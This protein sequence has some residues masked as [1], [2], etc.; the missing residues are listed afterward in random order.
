MTNTTRDIRQLPRRK[1]A[2]N[3]I[4]GFEDVARELLER[5]EEKNSGQMPDA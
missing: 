3:P 1:A 4:S 5:F 2:K